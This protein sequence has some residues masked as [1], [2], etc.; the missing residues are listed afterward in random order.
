M[1]HFVDRPANGAIRVREFLASRG[2]VRR[3]R[4]GALQ[5]RDRAGHIADVPLHQPEQIASLGGKIIAAGDCLQ[6][7]DGGGGVARL[8]PRQGEPV[9]QGWV[10]G[11]EP[12]GGLAVPLRGLSVLPDRVE[13]I[14][15]RDQRLWRFRSEFAR[16][17]P[18]ARRLVEPALIPI[19]LTAPEVGHH[20]VRPEG[21]R[22]AER[23][24]GG[25]GITGGQRP[26]AV[27]E[28]PAVLALGVKPFDGD[29]SK[30]RTN[31]E[32][33]GGAGPCDGPSHRHKCKGEPWSGAGV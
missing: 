16:L 23:L 30:G 18:V 9:E 17:A 10:L 6:G 13:V 26:V 21:Q 22:A 14:A 24:D 27:R 20:R 12:A 28:E 15:Q 8:E 19:G 32:G 4:D 29:H 11:L 25:V 7:F 2:K 3:E 5:R 1:D 31:Q 33:H